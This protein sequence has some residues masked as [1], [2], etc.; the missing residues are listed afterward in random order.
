MG[1]PPKPNA[2]IFTYFFQH[3]L[4]LHQIYWIVKYVMLRCKKIIYFIVCWS[5]FNHLAKWIFV[6][7]RWT[8]GRRWF[9]L[10]HSIQCT[11]GAEETWWRCFRIH[12]VHWVHWMRFLDL[13]WILGSFESCIPT[14]GNFRVRISPETGEVSTFGELPEGNWKW[15]GTLTIGQRDDLNSAPVCHN[16]PL[17]F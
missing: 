13:S 16:M 12:W 6:L 17:Y 7:C 15:H 9:H 5:P 1:Q 4:F 3:T 10:W 8:V 11:T 14:F 2:A